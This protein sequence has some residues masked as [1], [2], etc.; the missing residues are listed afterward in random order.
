[1]LSLQN[2]YNEEDLLSF[3]EKIKKNLH[4]EKPEFF[5]EPKFDGV[6]IELNYQTG[7]LCPH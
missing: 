6:A 3:I 5:L 4:P 2:T 7:S 1:M